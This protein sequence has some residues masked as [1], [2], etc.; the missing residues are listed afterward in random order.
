MNKLDA[1]LTIDWTQMPTYNTIMAVAAG[2]ALLNIVWMGRLI[3]K[4]RPV[5]LV[6]SAVTF[7][8]LGAILTITGAHM[9]LTWPFAKYFPFDNIIFGEPSLAFG[10]LLLGG[11]ILLWRADR[12]V[13]LDTESHDIGPEFAASLAPMRIFIFGLGLSLGAIA[14]A[15]LVFQLFAAPPEEPISGAFAQWPW[16]EAI[17]MSGLF[18]FVGIGAVFSLSPSIN[19]AAESTRPCSNGSPASPSVSRGSPSCCLAHST[20][21]PTS[22]SSSTRCPPAAECAL[23]PHPIRS[24][25]QSEGSSSSHCA[26]NPLVGFG[27]AMNRK[28]L[29]VTPGCGVARFAPIAGASRAADI[30]AQPCS[31]STNAATA[32]LRGTYVTEPFSVTR[33]RRE[34]PASK[35]RLTLRVS[36]NPLAAHVYTQPTH[37]ELFM[38]EVLLF[39]HAQG[40]TACVG[41]CADAVSASGQIAACRP[42]LTDVHS[43][44][45][46]MACHSFERMAASTRWRSAVGLEGCP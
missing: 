13:P 7:I 32:A 17:F 35:R 33:S 19:W 43:P 11:A 9:T 46:K 1:A 28:V 29:D 42:Y 21:S 25:R 27:T 41:V 14:I 23:N 2:A 45:L 12:H 31:S 4:G 44:R 20:T 26:S 16:V 39:H 18:G 36:G 37:R 8:V 40:L 24:S 30:N 5:H 6:G 38:T 22:A 15:G 3:L 10:V 34:D